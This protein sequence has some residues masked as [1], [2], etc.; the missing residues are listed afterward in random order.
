MPRFRAQV[1]NFSAG[2]ISPGA[3]D[4][5]DS[6]VWQAGAEHLENVVVRRGGGLRTRPGMRIARTLDNVPNIPVRQQYSLFTPGLEWNAYR[7]AG[8][9]FDPQAA[10]YEMVSPLWNDDP[11]PGSIGRLEVAPD[12]I[13][14]GILDWERDGRRG[15]T[16]LFEP[17][18]WKLP[19]PNTPLP[20][21]RTTFGFIG[22]LDNVDVMAADDGPARFALAYFALQPNVW[23]LRQLT[24]HSVTLA[25]TQAHRMAAVAPGIYRK[26][27]ES[28]WHP[29]FQLWGRIAGMP[30][31]WW[32]LAP[33]TSQSRA[34]ALSASPLNGLSFGTTRSVTVPLRPVV[35]A[36]RL[37]EVEAYL[38][39]E[40]GN[41]VAYA[42][43]RI[44]MVEL[45]CDLVAEADFFTY[46]ASH[47]RFANQRA[48]IPSGGVNWAI[49]RVEG[50]WSEADEAV[51]RGTQQ[52]RVRR[53]TSVTRAPN[54]RPG[55]AQIRLVEWTPRPGEHLIAQVYQQGAQVLRI[56]DP[57]EPV[58]VIGPIGHDFS[59]IALDE[60]V[61]V[62]TNDAIYCFHEDLHPPQVLRR[63][64][65]GSFEWQDM[66]F[67]SI[68]EEADEPYWGDGNGIR[69]G[70]VAFGR[71]VLIGSKEFPN[72]LAF[73]K[74]GDYTTYVA[75]AENAT[76]SDAFSAL[77][78]GVE[79]LHAGIQGRRLVMFGERGEYFLQ[80]LEL[81]GRALSFRQTSSHG[82]PRGGR[83]ITMG[84]TIVFRQAGPGGDGTDLRMMVFSDEESGFRTPSLA[85][86]SPELVKGISAFAYQHGSAD[87]GGGRLWCV[88]DDGTMS[89][90][91]V[92]RAAGVNAW[93]RVTPPQGVAIFE[94]ASIANRVFAMADMD[95]TPDLIELS[96]TDEAGTVLDLAWTTDHWVPGSAGLVSFETHVRRILDSIFTDLTPIR[97]RPGAYET[98]IQVVS[99]L[100]P[101]F[102]VEWENGR[103]RIDEAAA[104]LTEGA[105]VE[106]GIPVRWTVRTLPVLFPGATGTSVSVQKTRLV[107]AMVDYEVTTEG[108]E[109]LA[110]ERV[111]R[112]ENYKP[113]IRNWP[114]RIELEDSRGLWLPFVTVPTLDSDTIVRCK[115]GSRRGW[116]NRT[117][118]AMRGST[119]VTIVGVSF[120]V[121]GSA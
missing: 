88:K 100:D 113:S 87:D 37:G 67:A 47:P 5:I 98:R 92:D 105:R 108:T 115:L 35:P 45:A 59:G 26:A 76:L 66:P 6:A 85:P 24:F 51:L 7:G 107:R 95:G 27:A 1:G 83:A 31:D 80:S 61:F 89:V 39:D 16:P 73:S 23:P 97:E 41:A 58:E 86:Y 90:L 50:T 19:P 119:P 17:D 28:T 40:D 36:S 64:G 46:G 78:A 120:M 77:T 117:T 60:M 74:V 11:V 91:S 32:T 21:D 33:A 101:P 94:V 2:E 118:L 99:D 22:K 110:R 9:Q 103:P 56:T 71:M 49:R 93:S 48:G 43:D 29:K 3:Q 72:M 79:N 69:S 52:A 81:S 62:P 121:A 70:A 42:Y 13:R 4:R 12:D 44:V 102:F 112:T 116:R 14:D 57:G 15:G 63:G 111:L 82:S 20:A 53:E 10:M 106:V 54:V 104:M 75:P 8:R 38:V 68:P 96:Y 18:N 84:D 114:R 30:N 55:N 25:A 65:T 34:G 109:G